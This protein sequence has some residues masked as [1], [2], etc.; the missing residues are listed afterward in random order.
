MEPSDREGI[1]QFQKIRACYDR[2]SRAIFSE[3]ALC[4]DILILTCVRRKALADI[5]LDALCTLSQRNATT[6][7]TTALAPCKKAPQ[8]RG[9]SVAGVELSRCVRRL[10]NSAKRRRC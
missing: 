2:K 9:F 7:A 6:A 1:A 3:H 8:M 5:G 10:S 4:F